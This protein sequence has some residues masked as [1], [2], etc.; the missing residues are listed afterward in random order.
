M[1]RFKLHAMTKGNIDVRMQPVIF[2]ARYG[3]AMVPGADTKGRFD[4]EAVLAKPGNFERANAAWYVNRA[5]IEARERDS[6]IFWLSC[7]RGNLL[8]AVRQGH[9]LP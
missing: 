1:Q 9:R 4:Y 5:R 6:V 8:D 3:F 7:A 2:G